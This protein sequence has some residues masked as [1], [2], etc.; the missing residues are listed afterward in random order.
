MNRKNIHVAIANDADLA[1][2]I[3]GICAAVQTAYI[4]CYTEI[5]AEKVLN[6]L[7]IVVP[8]KQVRILNELVPVLNI[9]F[10]NQQKFSYRL[11]HEHEVKQALQNGSLFFNQLCKPQNC[12]FNRS[13]DL[14]NHGDMDGNLLAQQV[15]ST[16][17]TELNKAND[18]LAGAKFYLKKQSLPHCAF[19]LHQ[20]F[21]LSYRAIELLVM[22]AEK[23][24]HRVQIHQNYIKPYVQGLATLFKP[25]NEADIYLLYLLDEAYLAVRY[26]NNYQIT[27]AEIKALFE[28]AR[29]LAH[30]A[31]RVYQ[32]VLN[33]YFDR[34]TNN[35]R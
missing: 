23:K 31:N 1:A 19:M 35:L 12:L 11:F 33:N 8:N 24:T 34:E 7:L 16:Y 18:F 22:G 32:R 27:E 6:E 3:K 21:D 30:L 4:F 15:K 20:F 5:F 29:L 17:T 10:S 28:K 9:V 26:E 25:G 14:F 2:L 13:T